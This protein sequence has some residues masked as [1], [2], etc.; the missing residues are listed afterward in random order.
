MSEA[1]GAQ[2]D[3]LIFLEY[4]FSKRQGSLIDRLRNRCFPVTRIP[5]LGNASVGR[6]Y[7]RK[8]VKLQDP[9]GCP[10]GF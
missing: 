8:V 9:P 10:D 4:Y 5:D 2:L 7:E 6:A 1:K 3:F